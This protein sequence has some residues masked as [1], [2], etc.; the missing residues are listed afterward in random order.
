V[1]TRQL[2]SSAITDSEL[3]VMDAAVFAGTSCCRTCRKAGRPHMH[4]GTMC[5][6][7]TCMHCNLPCNAPVQRS[8][9]RMSMHGNNCPKLVEDRKVANQQQQQQ[10]APS[11]DEVTLVDPTIVPSLE[12]HPPPECFGEWIPLDTGWR[13]VDDRFDAKPELLVEIVEQLREHVPGFQQQGPPPKRQRTHEAVPEPN[14]SVQS[15]W[16][17]PCSTF[18]RSADISCSA[19]RALRIKRDYNSQCPQC[20]Q[21]SPLTRAYIG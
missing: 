4:N 12:E 3:E 6:Y 1:L 2:Q 7:R 20:R 16:T 19:K 17:R 5:R 13:L 14:D 9:G 21:R 10:Q 15:V 18:S 11:A 8:R